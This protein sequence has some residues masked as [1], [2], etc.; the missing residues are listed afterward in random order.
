MWWR[1]GQRCWPAAGLA[2]PSAAPPAARPGPPEPSYC[3]PRMPANT[4]G[5]DSDAGIRDD[6]GS[7]K[8][9]CFAQYTSANVAFRCDRKQHYLKGK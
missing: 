2:W 3:S 7:V 9:T 1:D 5:S 4:H 8:I 6:L